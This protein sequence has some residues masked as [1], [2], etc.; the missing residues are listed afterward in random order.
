M[1]PELSRFYGIV[2]RMYLIDRE[3]PPE[4]IHIKYVEY[5][6]VMELT[7]LNIIEGTLPKR[8]RQMVREWAEI[9]QDE[10]IKMWRTQNFHKVAPLE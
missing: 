3:H 4:H 1:V 5:Q 2:I 7:H 9:H 10:L 6:A 8:C